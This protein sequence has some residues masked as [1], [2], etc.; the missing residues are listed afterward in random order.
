[1]IV[2]VGGYAGEPISGDLT[3]NGSAVSLSLIN[4]VYETSVLSGDFVRL[5]I[6]DVPVPAAAPLLLGALGLF[7]LVRRKRG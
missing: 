4:G 6:S 3:V 1:M 2:F 5:T 7:G